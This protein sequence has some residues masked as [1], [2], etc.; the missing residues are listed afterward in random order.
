MIDSLRKFSVDDAKSRI[1]RQQAA[2][3]HL[4]RLQ[5]HVSAGRRSGFLN[6][7]QNKSEDI[8]VQTQNRP[9]QLTILE[10]L[11]KKKR[12]VYVDSPNLRDPKAR[13]NRILV[14]ESHT[15]IRQHKE[16]S[17]MEE[18]MKRIDKFTNIAEID[19]F[20]SHVAQMENKVSDELDEN[21]IEVEDEE[22]YN[23]DLESYLK[24]FIKKKVREDPVLYDFI[25][26]L[27]RECLAS[28]LKRMRKA[29]KEELENFLQ[30]RSLENISEAKFLE[31][32]LCLDLHPADILQADRA[33]VF[34]KEGV[35]IMLDNYDSELV[36]QVYQHL[37]FDLEALSIEIERRK[38]NKLKELERKKRL[39][40]AN[41]QE[42]EETQEP[43][44]PN[45]ERS[46]LKDDAVSSNPITRLRATDMIKNQ[47]VADS[48]RLLIDKSRRLTDGIIKNQKQLVNSKVKI[49]DAMSPRFRLISHGSSSRR[50]RSSDSD[51]L[52]EAEDKQL[53]ET[54]KEIKEKFAVQLQ[55]RELSKERMASIKKIRESKEHYHFKANSVN[56]ASEAALSSRMKKKHEEKLQSTGLS[57]TASDR[58]KK[59]IFLKDRLHPNKS[60]ET[61]KSKIQTSHFRTVSDFS[62]FVKSRNS[63][64][65]PRMFFKEISGSTGSSFFK[66][67]LKSDKED[68]KPS[69]LPIL[70]Q[71][72]QS[73]ESFIQKFTR[74]RGECQSEFSMATA[75][76]KEV[77]SQLKEEGKESTALYNQIESRMGQQVRTVTDEQIKQFGEL[78]FKNRCHLKVADLLVNMMADKKKA[79]ELI[80]PEEEE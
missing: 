78:R 36:A 20:L 49:V 13:I 5:Q 26:N 17:K 7:A 25:E 71:H 76:S 19:R 22:E 23:K 80:K 29:S 37:G 10:I 30:H 9:L 45:K 18:R 68:S 32:L 6:P 72:E 40:R 35:D 53:R 52:R 50:G 62:T 70:P 8:P 33:K 21:F 59:T 51:G 16:K 58:V 41:Q 73:T 2:E 27:S 64:A 11:Q 54:S 66:N 31:K 74:F 47:E 63:Q 56:L 67:T 42:V 3:V 14:G 75:S 77:G 61:S 60:K 79:V 1:M 44:S 28:D 46:Q 38:Q 4:V 34:I 15:F 65:Q 48:V 24:D 57:S 55:A 12:L 69:K 43:A 39:A